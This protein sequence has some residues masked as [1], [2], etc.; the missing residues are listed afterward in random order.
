ML[1]LKKLDREITEFL[2]SQTAD[3][4]QTFINE[5]EEEKSL[6]EEK[7]AQMTRKERLNYVFAS[8]CGMFLDRVMSD[9]SLDA[10]TIKPVP[11]TRKVSL[12]DSKNTVKFNGA[13]SQSIA[14]PCKVSVKRKTE[15]VV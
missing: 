15:T 6:Q 9:G 2:Q 11:K 12:I 5:Y 10:P 13:P 3:D 4:L 8:N 14:K 7:W 1:D